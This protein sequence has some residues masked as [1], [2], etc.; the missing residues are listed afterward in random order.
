MTKTIEYSIIPSEIAFHAL[1]TSLYTD[2]LKAPVREILSNAIDAHNRAKN[3]R[4]IEIKVP[5]AL[6]PQFRIRDFG[7]GLAKEDMHRLYSSLF[8]SDKNLVRDNEVGGFGV[9]AKSPFAY[10]DAFTVESYFNGTHTIYSAF[11]EGAKA[12]TLLELFQETTNEPN[13][14][15]V[16]YP[17]T[18]KDQAALHAIVKK[19]VTFCGHDVEITGF[20][21]PVVKMENNPAYVKIKNAYFTNDSSVLKGREEVYV[22]MGNV[23]YPVD[24]SECH[25][26]LLNNLNSMLVNI[27]SRLAHRHVRHSHNDTAQGGLPFWEHCIFDMPIGSL[28]PAMSRESLIINDPLTVSGFIDAYK[29]L[30]LDLYARAQHDPVVA[31]I[32]LSSRENTK[33]AIDHPFPQE[34]TALMQQ[35]EVLDEHSRFW[36]DHAIELHTGYLREFANESHAFDSILKF[37]FATRALKSPYLHLGGGRHREVEHELIDQQSTALFVFKY[38]DE[39]LIKFLRACLNDDEDIYKS[40]AVDSYLSVR[41]TDALQQL[42]SRFNKEDFRSVRRIILLAPIS[43][44]HEE[45]ILNFTNTLGS[46]VFI[47]DVAQKTYQKQITT[48]NTLDCEGGLRHS[49][50]TVEPKRLNASYWNLTTQSLET[51]Q[52]VE[53]PEYF[54]EL[55]TNIINAENAESLHFA[56]TLQERSLETIYFLI[57]PS[58]EDT[59][60]IECQNVRD[61]LETF[62]PIEEMPLDQE[63]FYLSIALKN[64]PDHPLSDAK[65][66]LFFDDFR[67]LSFLHEHSDLEEVYYTIGR[68]L[69]EVMR[70]IGDILHSRTN[71]STFISQRYPLFQ[72]LTLNE[73]NY[74]NYADVLKHY[75]AYIDSITPFDIPV[76]SQSDKQSL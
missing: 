28:K 6:D 8:S 18:K 54:I 2:R 40:H 52:L 63:R 37:H 68:H 3:A 10:T 33:S 7:T 21:E 55:R 42:F 59:L 1:T 66:S 31:H 70:K 4:A 46:N 73:R 32:L 9:G 39:N 53:Q 19:E 44:E 17:V 56:Q 50:D 71:N 14:L 67:A 24:F 41:D 35:K 61:L 45:K 27:R 16:S 29:T 62:A 12:P 69:Y 11:M 65:H 5:T 25:D 43:L 22:R 38:K 13:G 48:S 47:F 64:K 76:L 57:D 36:V 34:H 58:L 15:A 23:V 20:S 26:P 49:K 30:F 74:N 51:T 72:S 60:I 75:V